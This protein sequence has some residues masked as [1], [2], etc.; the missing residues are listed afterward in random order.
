M[1]GRTTEAAKRCCDEVIKRVAE[2]V[3]V[4]AVR[5]D[6]VFLAEVLDPDYGHDKGSDA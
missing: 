4:G 2:S 1:G 6:G 5:A 3:R